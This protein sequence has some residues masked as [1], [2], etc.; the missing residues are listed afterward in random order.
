MDQNELGQTPNM[1]EKYPVSLEVAYPEK[2]SRLLAFFTILFLIPK[3]VIMAPHFVVLYFL[4][5]VAFLVWI[6]GQLAVLF[7]GRYPRGAFD[8][9]VGV[10]RWQARTNAYFMGLTDKYPPFSL[11]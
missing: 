11:S 2:S 10:Q 5:I 8:F 1:P 6:Y 7:T 9:I 4:A 3:V